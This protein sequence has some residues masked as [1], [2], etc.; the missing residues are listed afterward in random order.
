MVDNTMIDLPKLKEILRRIERPVI[1]FILVALVILEILSLFFQPVK[2]L[3]A[4][5][6]MLLIFIILFLIFRYMAEHLED[7][8]GKTP[9]L[10]QFNEFNSAMD[11]LFKDL[12]YIEQVDF[13]GLSGGLFYPGIQSRRIKINKMRVLILNPDSNV[14]LNITKSEKKQKDLKNNIITQQN[15]REFFLGK[16]VTNLEV[17]VYDFEPLFFAVIVDKKKGFFGFFEPVDMPHTHFNV[18]KCFMLT[19]DTNYENS[20]LDD[21]NKWFDKIFEKYSIPYSKCN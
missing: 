11:M 12:E 2:D 18:M 14:E 21:L 17:K 15:D 5:K 9:S 8:S 13:I 16:S 6:S 4:D 7:I 3:T 1:Y 19:Q 20:I 10:N